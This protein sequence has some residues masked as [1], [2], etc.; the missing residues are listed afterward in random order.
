MCLAVFVLFAS[1][2]VW[3][4]NCWDPSD[5]MDDPLSEV[6]PGQWPSPCFYDYTTLKEGSTQPFPYGASVLNAAFAWVPSSFELSLSWVEKPLSTEV[7][8]VNPR[9]PIPNVSTASFQ[10]PLVFPCRS[11][12]GGAR[13]KGRRHSIVG[14]TTITWSVT[15]FSGFLC[16]EN[17]AKGSTNKGFFLRGHPQRHKCRVELSWGRSPCLSGFAVNGPPKKHLVF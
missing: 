3:Q 5:L 16:L 2:I 12:D 10:N 4:A 17:Q 9:P 13:R 8:W 11:S 15:S 14:F 6:K 7:R 1:R